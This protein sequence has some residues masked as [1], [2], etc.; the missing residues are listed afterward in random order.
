MGEKEKNS[1]TKRGGFDFGSCSRFYYL[2][3]SS[4]PIFSLLLHFWISRFGAVSE[5]TR[6]E[7]ENMRKYDNRIIRN[8]FLI[9]LR[10][11]L[12][13]FEPFFFDPDV[14]AASSWAFCAAIVLRVCIL[15]VA[16]GDFEKEEFAK[17]AG[18]LVDSFVLWS[19]SD[20][21][22]S[23]NPLVESIRSK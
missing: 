6:E 1:H 8:Q 22:I 17:M 16:K 14:A 13:F 4:L 9:T 12:Y 23:L 18:N 10:V 19:G 21:G 11:L 3:L 2:L 20:I 15:I 5:K 7:M